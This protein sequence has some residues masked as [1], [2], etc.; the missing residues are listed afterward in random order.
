MGNPNQ[1]DAVTLEV[2]PIIG[3]QHDAMMAT[4]STDDGHIERRKGQAINPESTD[5]SLVSGR[6]MCHFEAEG[7]A[8]RPEVECKLSPRV[9]SSVRG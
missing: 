5:R 7:T 3:M 2:R 9:L 4:R 1:N 8:I 6:E